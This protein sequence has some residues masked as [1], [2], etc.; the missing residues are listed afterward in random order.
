LHQA[1]ASIHQE[2]Q[3]IGDGISESLLNA[4]VAMVSEVGKTNP[5]T[6]SP[7]ML[8]LQCALLES[9]QALQNQ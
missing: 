9:L 2:L 4:F 8:A 6:F 7:S 3:Q 1:L 5:I